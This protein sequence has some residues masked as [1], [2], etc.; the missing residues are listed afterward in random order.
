MFKELIEIFFWKRSNPLTLKVW[1]DFPTQNDTPTWNFG[2][3]G[4][5]ILNI[6]N[7]RFLTLHPWKT[8]F[9]YVMQIIPINDGVLNRLLLL[10]PKVQICFGFLKILFFIEI[11]YTIE[12]IWEKGLSLKFPIW[13][14][15]GVLLRLYLQDRDFWFQSQHPPNTQEKE[16]SWN[17]EGYKFFICFCITLLNF[18]WHYTIESLRYRVVEKKRLMFLFLFKHRYKL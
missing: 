16:R 14:I 7:G 17:N 2:E 12:I 5:F 10:F 8:C 18:V 1:L 4:Y 6:D 11:I 15:K 3:V 13:S 9:W